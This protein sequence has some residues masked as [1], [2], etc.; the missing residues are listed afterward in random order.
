MLAIPEDDPIAP[1][2]GL[3]D[4][5]AGSRRIRRLAPPARPRAPG[6]AGKGLSDVAGFAEVQPPRTCL[7]KGREAP[8]ERSASFHSPL[9]GFKVTCF[10]EESLKLWT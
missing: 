5:D 3:D 2:V 8:I 9:S 1:T 4:V 6:C 10:D 7:G